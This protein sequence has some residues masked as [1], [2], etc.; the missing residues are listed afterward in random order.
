MRPSGTQNFKFTL[1]IGINTQLLLNSMVHIH[2]ENI[3][4]DKQIS[5]QFHSGNELQ[6]KKSFIGA[7]IK[8]LSKY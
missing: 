5:A 8:L 1:Q 7:N 2:L 4:F 3:K 6:I